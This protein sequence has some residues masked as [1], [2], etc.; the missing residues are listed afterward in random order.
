MLSTIIA[1]KQWTKTVAFI[2]FKQSQ[3]CPHDG[4]RWTLVQSSIFVFCVF[5]TRYGSL[6]QY[7]SCSCGLHGTKSWFVLHPMINSLLEF[8][9]VC[10][11]HT[12][13]STSVT[14]STDKCAGIRPCFVEIWS[15]MSSLW[16]S[17]AFDVDSGC[18]IIVVLWFRASTWCDFGFPLVG[19]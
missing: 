10:R 2:S 17:F 12:A 16:T 6:G 15:N 19:P 11:S 18:I 3:P 7:L 9:A 13:F 4:N 8:G 14:C 5:C 1:S